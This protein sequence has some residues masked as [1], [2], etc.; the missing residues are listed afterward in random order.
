MFK[1]DPEGYR[2]LLAYRKA[3]ELKIATERFVGNF[4]KTKTFIDLADQMSRSARSGVKNIVEGWMRN[5]TKEYFTFLGYSIGSNEEL[6]EDAT[7]IVTGVY[8]N[9][10]GIRG[11]MGYNAIQRGE[12]DV[13][14]FYPP[15]LNVDPA[16]E[17]FLRAKELGLLLYRLQQSLDVKMDKEMT[18]PTADKFRQ[19]D[20]AE[21]TADQEF[22]KYLDSIGLVH[23]PNGQYIHK[24][25]GIAGKKDN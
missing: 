25:D 24:D 6:K 13:I 10:M 7:D 19:R 1:K 8:K 11:V 21:K 5:T 22:Q 4:P 18:K 15:P 2:K 17:L 20:M 12:L 14:R 16:V 23:L 9:L 3:S